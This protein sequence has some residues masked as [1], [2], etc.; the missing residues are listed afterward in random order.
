LD[1]KIFKKKCY[2]TSKSKIIDSENSGIVFRFISALIALLDTPISITGDL[3]IKKNRV[4]S[5]L[6]KGLKQLKVSINKTVPLTIKGP[7]IPN[8]IYIS[9]KDSQPISALLIA[10][11]FS[12]GKET[13]IFVKNSGEKPWIDLTLSWFNFLNIKYEK[14]EYFYYKTF[15]NTKINGFEKIIESDFSSIYYPII[16]ALI[17]NLNATINIDFSSLGGDKKLISILQEMNANIDIK[18]DKIL[19]RK[20][21]KLKNKKIDVN[22][23]IDALPILSVLGCFIDG[24][25]ILY[26]AAIAKK[27]ES[28]RI[29]AMYT[30]LKKMGANIKKKKDGLIIKKSFLKGAHL[31]S[32]KDHRI[33]MSLIIAALSA[34]KDSFIENTSSIKKSYPHFLKDFNL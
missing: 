33:T 12:K 22:D 30:E 19:I 11:S 23:F 34:K 15:S 4:I 32:H 16:Y 17:N 9:G 26:N 6:I 24:E 29:N 2:L 7:M 13:E 25:T 18:K 14:K 1:R 8:K 10:T 5:P 21:S 20:G 27:K 28:N 3:S 31:Y